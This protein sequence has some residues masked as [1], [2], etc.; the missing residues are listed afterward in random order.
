MISPWYDSRSWAGKTAKNLIHVEMLWSERSLFY[1]AW[2]GVRNERC[3]SKLQKRGKRMGG[4]G[5]VGKEQRNSRLRGKIILLFYVIRLSNSNHYILNT[6]TE[7]FSTLMLLNTYIYTST[8]LPRSFSSLHFIIS[9][10]WLRTRKTNDK[11]FSKWGF[12]KMFWFYTAS[13]LK[14]RNYIFSSSNKWL[15]VVKRYSLPKR[16]FNDTNLY[17]KKYDGS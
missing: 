4:Y 9:Q 3:D 11:I 8:R 2:V 6:G 14:F 10:R 5:D 15:T 7:S 16:N 17:L 13:Q 1:I 12:Y